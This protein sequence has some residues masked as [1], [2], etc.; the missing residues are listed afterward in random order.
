MCVLRQLYKYPVSPAG[1]SGHCSNVLKLEHAVVLDAERL[2][3]RVLAGSSKSRER[4]LP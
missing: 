3:N 2:Q 4:S 1:A